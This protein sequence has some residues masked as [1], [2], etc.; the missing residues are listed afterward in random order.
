MDRYLRDSLGL[1]IPRKANLYGRSIREDQKPFPGMGT[2]ID[3]M[4][5]KGLNEVQWLVAIFDKVI[6]QLSTTET[7]KGGADHGSSG[8]IKGSAKMVTQ[9]RP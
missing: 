8:R 5:D 9:P 4:M 2:S 7:N 1:Q 3:F 6:C